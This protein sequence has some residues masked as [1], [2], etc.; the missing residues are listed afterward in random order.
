MAVVESD[1]SPD[2]RAVPADPSMFARRIALR[3]YLTFALLAVL[4]PIVLASGSLFY[5]SARYAL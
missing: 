4:L 5:H 3:S 1:A 2:F